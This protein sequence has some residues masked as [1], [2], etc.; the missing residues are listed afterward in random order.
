M[1]HRASVAREIQMGLGL[2]LL[3]V[4]PLALLAIVFAVKASLAPLRRFGERLD[5]RN[6]RD[7]APV[8]DGDIPS[9][10]APV[11]ATL[12]RLLARLKGSFD[13]ERSFAANA[14]HELRTPLAGAIAQAQRLQSE[15]GDTT[16]RARAAEI[17]AT[18]KRLTR[19]SERLMQL[20][21]AEGGRLRMDRSADLRAVARVVVDD[22]ARAST[23]GRIALTLPD[24]AV[25]SDIDPDAFGILC[26]NLVENALRHGAETAPVDVT[27]TQDAQ[28]IV[29]N[30]GPVLPRD[31][32]DR[33]TVRFER[34]NPGTD[35][36]GLG[37]AI[38]VAIADRIGSQLI[39]E[40]PRP[41][42]SSGFQASL[43]LPTDPAETIAR[44]A[45]RWT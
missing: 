16:A 23:P 42:A 41:G 4:V 43:S 1:E 2:P 12:N 27:L 9:E 40:S 32:L 17:E 11:A 31:T 10:I 5:A 15:T 28:L 45:M 20:A 34:A 24:T 26:R 33:L 8:P 37:L 18:L 39:L 13:A 19:L 38:V 44:D 14:A 21:R 25:M 6:A 22:L 29:S 3:I 35:G 36:S 7:L 30:D